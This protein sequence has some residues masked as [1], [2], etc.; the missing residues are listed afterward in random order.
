MLVEPLANKLNSSFVSTGF[1]GALFMIGGAVIGAGITLIVFDAFIIVASA[2]GGAGL[3]MDG[4]HLIFR[5]LDMVDRS[6]ISDGAV[7]PLIIWVVLGA[8]AMAWQFKNIERWTHNA[9][10]ATDQADGQT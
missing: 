10:P 5:S 7:A 9:G 4:L 8:L 1:L 6:T 2:V 3:A